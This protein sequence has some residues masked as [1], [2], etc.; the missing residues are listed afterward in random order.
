MFGVCCMQEVPGAPSCTSPLGTLAAWGRRTA[1]CGGRLN[2]SELLAIGMAQRMC[3]HFVC[4]VK[5]DLE[6][7]R[8]EFNFTTNILQ[9][10]VAAIRIERTCTASVGKSHQSRCLN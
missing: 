8:H 2:R 3:D 10:A 9:N 6:H 5:G 7:V 1:H 4:V